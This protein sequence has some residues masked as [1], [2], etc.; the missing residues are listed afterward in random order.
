MNSFLTFTLHLIVSKMLVTEGNCYSAA[1]NT[2]NFTTVVLV[3]QYLLKRQGVHN[4]SS[5]TP[6]SLYL[7]LGLHL[8]LE[9]HISKC[10]L[11]VIC[12]G[13]GNVSR[14]IYLKIP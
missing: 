9:F 11:K 8:S 2:S 4:S 5:K 7:P 13:G 6:P 10:A 12:Q 1:I 14:E 3:L